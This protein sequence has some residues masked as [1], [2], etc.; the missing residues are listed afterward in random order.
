MFVWSVWGDKWLYPF[1]ISKDPY[2]IYS[3]T[4]GQ[5]GLPGFQLVRP[6]GK[7]LNNHQFVRIVCG[8]LTGEIVQETEQRT[9]LLFLFFNS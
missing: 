2:V 8:R 1:Q 3:H 5:K 6:T 9:K 4:K 7:R